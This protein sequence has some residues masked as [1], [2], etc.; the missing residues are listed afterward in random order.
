MAGAWKSSCTW[1]D[2]AGC[3]PP[4]ITI[5]TGGVMSPTA[6]PARIAAPSD[7]A[8]VSSK[9]NGRTRNRIELGQCIAP[10]NSRPAFQGEADIQ[11]RRAA[12]AGEFFTLLRRRQTD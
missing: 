1:V 12:W 8:L 6:A 9:I 11:L 10:E 2:I 4:F 3:V 5:P 7:R